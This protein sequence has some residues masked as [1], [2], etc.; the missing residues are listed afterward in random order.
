MAAPEGNRNAQSISDEVLL[1]VC[2]L[3][4]HMTVKSACEAMEIS[5]QAFWY[6]KNRDPHIEEAYRDNV[7]KRGDWLY[8]TVTEMAIAKMDT[9][10]IFRLMKLAD[11]AKFNEKESPA[12][13]VNVDQTTNISSFEMSVDDMRQ[14][15]AET[16]KANGNDE[17]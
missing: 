5:R 4:Q 2:A 6:R 17:S 1:A 3:C 9:A 15:V 16:D 11:P 7:G 8:E 14:I 12:V 13:Q 10:A